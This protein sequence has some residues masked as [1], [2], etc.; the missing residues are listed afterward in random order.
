MV[1]YCFDT[2][3]LSTPNE[4]T[5]PDIHVSMWEN[6][7]QFIADGHVGVTLEIFEEMIEI[8]GGLGEFIHDCK[9]VILFEVGEGGWDWGT[10]IG[11]SNRMQEVHEQF[12]SEFTGGS[13]KTICLNDL[14]IIALAKTLGV[15]VLSMEGRVSTNS[16]KKRR[17]PD[18]CDSEGVDHVDIRE[19]L[20]AEGLKF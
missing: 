12:I 4:Q 20:R 14:S 15:P 7:R 5:P 8:D 18:I 13:K 10:Y 16:Q 9:E 3:G 11:H 17:I 1:K 2:S 6:I 19:F